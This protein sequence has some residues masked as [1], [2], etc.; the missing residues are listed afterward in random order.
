MRRKPSRLTTGR[1]QLLRLFS[2][3]LA[4]E[5]L[6]DNGVRF[7]SWVLSSCQFQWWNRTST[8]DRVINVSPRSS[9]NASRPPSSQHSSST[10]V[11]CFLGKWLMSYDLKRN[12]GLKPTNRPSAIDFW[13]VCRTSGRVESVMDFEGSGGLVIPSF[14]DRGYTNPRIFELSSKGLV[15]PQRQTAGSAVFPKKIPLSGCY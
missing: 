2:T 8:G 11:L 1:L 9:S 13:Y 4:I 6:T 15:C 3:L 14:V 5:A 12:L 10:S 7:V